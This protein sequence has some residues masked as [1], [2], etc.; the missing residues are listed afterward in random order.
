M[1][2]NRIQKAVNSIKTVCK[3]HGL[4]AEN[5]SR[6]LANRFLELAGIPPRHNLARLKHIVRENLIMEGK[7]VVL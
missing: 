4:E 5:K 6:K 1:S 2:E 7:E 3:S